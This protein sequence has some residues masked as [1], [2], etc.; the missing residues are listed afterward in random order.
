[1]RDSDYIRMRLSSSG[2]PRDYKF[3]LIILMFVFAV[4][5]F[6]VAVSSILFAKL[7][8]PIFACFVF[9]FGSLIV[10]IIAFLLE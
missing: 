3:L 1:M 8:A 2:K 4:L 9:L 7:T 10:I 5:I 6:L